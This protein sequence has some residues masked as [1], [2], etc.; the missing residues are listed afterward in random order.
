MGG[1]VSSEMGLSRVVEA[2]Q[3]ERRRHGVGSEIAEM[4][5]Y[6]EYSLSLTSHF[7]CL[8]SLFSFLFPSFFTF[9]IWFWTTRFSS[10][11]FLFYIFFLRLT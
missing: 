11:F 2:S 1:D 7:L 10:S 9:S 8:A 5:L 3:R 4:G 6:S